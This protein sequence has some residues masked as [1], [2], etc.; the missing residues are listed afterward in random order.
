MFLHRL[1]ELRP[2]GS[3]SPSQL[4]CR[5]IERA[6]LSH[7][8]AAT[9]LGVTPPRLSDLMRGKISAFGLES[10]VGMASAAGLE[11]AL[12]V[13][14]PAAVSRDTMVDPGAMPDDSPVQSTRTGITIRG[15]RSG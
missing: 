13:S 2:C 11:V 4:L 1:P 9:L 10:L 3:G 8:E 14:E 15:P 12:Q 7:T 6:S 5:S